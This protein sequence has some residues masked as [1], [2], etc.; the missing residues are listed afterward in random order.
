MLGPGVA[1]MALT[2]TRTVLMPPANCCNS[3]LKACRVCRESPREVCAKGRHRS[4]FWVRPDIAI[5]RGLRQVCKCIPTRSVNSQKTGG[6]GGIRTHG[7]VTRT[8]VFVF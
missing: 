8:T 6:E 3:F 5:G 4:V 7:T 1:Q 2:Q